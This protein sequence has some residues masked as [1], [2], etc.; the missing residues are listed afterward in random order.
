[1]IERL[2]HR[3]RHC[4]GTENGFKKQKHFM[5]RTTSTERNYRFFNFAFAGVLYN[6][7]QRVS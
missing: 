3:Y 2:I 6:V 5:V 1:M 7:W 4:W